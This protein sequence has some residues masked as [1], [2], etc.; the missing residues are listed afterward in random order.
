MASL[1]LYK[2]GSIVTTLR[3]EGKTEWFI[4][5]SSDADLPINHSS[6]S[7][8]CHC[9]VGALS[10]IPYKLVQH[11]PSFMLSVPE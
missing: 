4:G 10:S 11:E 7:R 5:R 3:L 2:D 9:A 1:E 8:R 6:V